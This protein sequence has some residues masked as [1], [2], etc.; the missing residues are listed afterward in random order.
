M[1]F[2]DVLKEWNGGVL[3]GARRR[4]AKSLKVTE[5]FISRLASGE[6]MPGEEMRIQLAREL[7]I[8]V[9][10]LMMLLGKKDIDASRV[11]EGIPSGRGIYSMPGLVVA[12]IPI[13]GRVSAA[14]CDFTPDEAPDGFLQVTM[15]PPHGHRLSALVISGNCMEPTAHDGEHIIVQNADSVRDGDLLVIEVDGQILLKRLHIEA[16]GTKEYRAD[17]KCCKHVRFNAA[18]VKILAKVYLIVSVRK[19]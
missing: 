13:V 8:S 7:K 11:R 18:G 14:G 16:D 3:R 6:L 9:D 1:N 12:Q 17:N 15:L 2:D 19:P 10:N 4:L 5:G